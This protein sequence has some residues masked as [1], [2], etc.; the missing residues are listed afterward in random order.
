[1]LVNLA[2]KFIVIQEIFDV[3]KTAHLDAQILKVTM[4]RTKNE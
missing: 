1:M 3:L 2:L 4:L